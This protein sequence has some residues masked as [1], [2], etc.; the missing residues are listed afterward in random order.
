MKEVK[1]PVRREVVVSFII[2]ASS[3][4]NLITPDTE[5]WALL[6]SVWHVRRH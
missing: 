6:M 1:K 2:S 4:D 5:Y 3:A